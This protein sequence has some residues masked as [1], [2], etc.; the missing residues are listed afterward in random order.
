[1]AK[2]PSVVRTWTCG[3]IGFDRHVSLW[4]CGSSKLQISSSSV[5]GNLNRDVSHLSVSTRIST[6][7]RTHALFQEPDV[8]RH[9]KVAS[10]PLVTLPIDLVIYRVK[11]TFN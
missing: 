9:P 3:G 11:L 6:R 4:S 2:N 5:L 7:L 1:M 8:L 10:Q